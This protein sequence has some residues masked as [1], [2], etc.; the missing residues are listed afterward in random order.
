MRVAQLACVALLIAALSQ[1]LQGAAS[2]AD[3]SELPAPDRF[4]GLA[5]F[6]LWDAGAPGALG[7]SPADTPTITLF[8]PHFGT[9]NGTAVIVAPG[10][11]YLGLAANLEGR[12]VADWFASR[13]VTAFVLKYRLG[14][15]YLYP[16][17]L[18]DAQRAI[19]LVRSRAAEFRIAAGRVGI[20]GFSAGGHLAA[21]A[22]TMFDAGT[23]DAADPV[24]RVS[25]RPDFIVLGY[26]WLNAMKKDQKGAISYCSVL[27][28]DAERCTSFERY[29]PDQHVSAQTPPAFI[30]HTTDDDTVPVDASVTFY[31]AVSI[32][33]GSAEMHVFAKGRHGSGLGLGDAAL[34]LWP[35]LLEAWMR[36]HGWLTPDPT[37]ATETRRI[38]TP[39]APRSPATAFSV[40]LSIR[41]LLGDPE[42]KAIVVKH[43]GREYVEQI[44]ESAR[45]NSLRAMSLFDPDHVTATTLAAV[46]SDLG[47]LPH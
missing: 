30:Y 29:S 43:L 9:G 18:L 26:P 25:S 27:Q 15:R 14:S 5:T 41:D 36:G 2:Q 19:R 10:G 13:G 4:L 34:D 8:R 35:T 44:P 17:P 39:P 7:K 38:L 46:E 22:G 3:P 42:A 28:V 16:I 1:E 24:D 33:G 37:V 32:A 45:A 23:S 21:T 31:R 47:K 40:D 6:P 12:Q 20:M 11:A